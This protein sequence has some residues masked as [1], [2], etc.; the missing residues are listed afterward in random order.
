MEEL[1]GL[2]Y[3][4]R[5]VVKS[6]ANSVTL[7]DPLEYMSNRHVFI[8]PRYK[9]VITVGIP[10]SDNHAVYS[11]SDYVP[12]GSVWVNQYRI[13]ENPKSVVWKNRNSVYEIYKEYNL[14]PLM[15]H[16]LIVVVGCDSDEGLLILNKSEFLEYLGENYTLF[17]T[18]TSETVYFN[19]EKITGPVVKCKLQK[20]VHIGS[21]FVPRYI[22]PVKED[23]YEWYKMSDTTIKQ[24]LEE[25]A[26]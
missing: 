5:V 6:T 20:P 26:V 1:F 8:T 22:P 4:L 17:D 19:I 14:R 2:P 25:Y 23:V 21:I 10:K 12:A 9:K 11:L 7:N 3:F 24:V 13:G 16:P 15:L 18:V